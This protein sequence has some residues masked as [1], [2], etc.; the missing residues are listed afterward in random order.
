MKDRSTAL[1]SSAMERE[2]TALVDALRHIGDDGL[3]GR[4]WRCQRERAEK[5]IGLLDR[6]PRMCRCVACPSCRRFLRSGWA[7]KVASRFQRADNADCSHATI[8]LD[9]VDDI[10]RVIDVV[11][12]LRV[13][14]RNLRDRHASV[15][16]R[17]ASVSA[18][19][20][21]PRVCRRLQLLR[22]WSHDESQ[23]IPEVFRRGA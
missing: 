8:V 12:D 1:A 6:W 23:N 17:W 10:S 7:E 3:A 11:R 18:Y 14:F 2:V 9:C 16:R 22:D 5:R 20:E 4:L 13:G 19:G 21:P 15:S